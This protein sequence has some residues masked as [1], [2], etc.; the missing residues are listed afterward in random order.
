[1]GALL[2]RELAPDAD[3]AALPLVGMGLAYAGVPLLDPRAPLPS[4]GFGARGRGWFADLRAGGVGLVSRQRRTLG[5]RR[6]RVSHAVAIGDVFCLWMTAAAGTPVTLIATA[7]SSRHDPHGWLEIQLLR[8]LAGRVFA[9]DEE[10]AGGLRAAGIDAVYVGNPLMD[11]IGHAATETLRRPDCHVVLLLPGS[12]VDAYRN[13]SALLRLA[14]AVAPHM[15]VRWLCALAP[16]L[17]RS[18]VAASAA[19]AGWSAA[20][21]LLTRGAATVLLTT[22]FSGGVRDADVVVSLAGTASEQAAGMGRPVVA[23]PG[24]GTQ[25]TPAFLAAQQ[26]LLGDALVAASGWTDAAA[27]VRRLLGDPDERLRRSAAGRLRMGPPGAVA[28][29]ARSILEQVDATPPS[30]SRAGP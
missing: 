2:A 1:M 10:T 15:P 12:R 16:T 29:I 7:K 3:V 27:D 20:D 14:D 4:G 24:A 8:R 19:A 25:F 5:R 6:G 17:D 23:F 11:A 26:R 28:R 13:L 30:T 21:T 18:A 9:R 22:D